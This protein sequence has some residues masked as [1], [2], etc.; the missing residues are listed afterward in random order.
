MPRESLGVRVQPIYKSVVQR[1]AKE[2]CRS[3]GYIVELALYEMFRHMIGRENKPG[4]R[5]ED[6]ETEINWHGSE[7]KKKP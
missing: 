7:E 2:M 5:M 6:E 4:K 3:D 1:Q